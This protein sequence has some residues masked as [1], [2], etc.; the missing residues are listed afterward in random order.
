MVLFFTKTLPCHAPA[1]NLFEKMIFCNM[2]FMLCTW[3]VLFSSY[4]PL[5]YSRVSDLTR[6]HCQLEI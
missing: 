6:Y 4:T 5:L 1:R 3:Q 2:R